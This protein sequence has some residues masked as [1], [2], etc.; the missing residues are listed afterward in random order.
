MNGRKCS[1]AVLCE[2]SYITDRDSD[3]T[4][5]RETRDLER[6][7]C[8]NSADIIVTKAPASVRFLHSSGGWIEHDKE[9]LDHVEVMLFAAYDRIEQQ[10]TVGDFGLLLGQEVTEPYHGVQVSEGS[11]YYADLVHDSRARALQRLTALRETVTRRHLAALAARIPVYAQD[12]RNYPL[13]AF[14]AT[15]FD[16]FKERPVL[17]L[18]DGGAIDLSPQPAYEPAGILDPN[19]YG[20]MHR[21]HL[22]RGAKPYEPAI[23]NQ[24]DSGLDLARRLLETHYPPE[25][26]Q[27]AAYLFAYP[28]D[29]IISVLIGD[30]GTGKT[31]F[32]Q[33]VGWSTGSVEVSDVSL[34]TSRSQFTP[35]EAALARSH[36]V[37]LDEGDASKSAPIPFGQLNRATAERFDVN[38]KFGAFKPGVPRLGALVLVGNDW[39][40]FDSTTRGLARRIAWAWDTTLPASIDKAVYDALSKSTPAHQYLLALL[41]AKARAL[42]R[43]GIEAARE[44]LMT[45]AVLQ[46]RQ[47][48]VEA[49]TSPLKL[50]L[51]DYIASGG[52]SDY[53]PAKRVQDII[54]EGDVGKVPTQELKRVMAMY[55][56]VSRSK[57]TDGG[58]KRVWEGVRERTAAAPE[59]NGASPERVPMLLPCPSCG[60]EGGV[61]NA[62]GVCADTVQ[63][64]ARRDEKIRTGEWV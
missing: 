37:V 38:V 6:L 33:W 48:M 34:L 21:T 11:D 59:R 36:V 2:H 20:L 58:F 19:S 3:V 42:R 43:L 28:A 40:S 9:S 32:W 27:L 24:E 54:A 51:D 53:V 14:P 13:A 50:V 23:L 15:E 41:V 57:R 47:R 8:L 22:D 46:A 60:R 7:A 35:L 5:A 30:S 64:E 16:K 26:L 39:P 17:A 18:A 52:K 12:Q 29:D 44:S 25:F 31:T 56:A 62:E 1:A 10:I 49:T 63:C 55:G 61:L 4:V 45:A